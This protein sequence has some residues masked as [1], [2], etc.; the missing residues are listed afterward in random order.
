MVSATP[1]SI[2]PKALGSQCSLKFVISFFTLA[3][4]SSSAS[5]TNRVR[6]KSALSFMFSVNFVTSSSNRL[7][8]SFASFCRASIRILQS[9]KC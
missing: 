9:T 1:A 4:N 5:G 6:T 7:N 2:L 8:N 3:W